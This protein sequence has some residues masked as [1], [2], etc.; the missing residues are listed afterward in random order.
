MIINPEPG[1]LSTFKI[2]YKKGG[3]F[4]FVVAPLSQ[5]FRD[6]IENSGSF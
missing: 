1:I 6:D 4:I 2:R 3:S 5:I